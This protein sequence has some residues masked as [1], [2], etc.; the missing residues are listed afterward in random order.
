MLVSIL[1]VV[2]TAFAQGGPIQTVAAAR[3][4]QPARGP[5]AVDSA[6]ALRSAHRAQES[7]EFTRKLYLPREAGVGS[8]HCDVRIG[9]W[10]VW[11]DETNDR[12]PPPENAHIIQ[13]RAKLLALLDS[14]AARFP[15]D[16]WVAAQEVRYL[17]EAKRFGDATRVAD[18]CVAGGSTYRCRAY[19]AVALHDSGAVAAADSASTDALA[20]MPDSVRCKWMDIKLLLDDDIADRYAHANCITRERLATTFWRLT[21][22]LY[23][24][25][26]DFRSEFLARVAHGEM[27]RD[28]R[29][30]MG[31]TTES[32]FRET[33]L[34]YGYDTWFVRDDPPAGS[35]AEAPVAG[36]REGGSGYNFVPA[37]EVF[38]SPVDLREDDWDL[39]QRTARTLYGPSYARRFTSIPAPQIAIF[40][41]GDSALVV[42][43]YD[44]H[45][46]TLFARRGLE[47]AL[48][49]VPIDSDKL[50]DPRGT[51]DS[52]AK[53]TG[54]LTTSAPWLP[55]IASVELLDSAYKSAARARVGV[56]LP[57]SEGRLGI[58][59]LLLF[60]PRSADSLPHRL[61]DALP[62]ALHSDEVNG[63][64][65]VGVFW[66]AYGVRPAGESFAVAIGIDRIQDGWMR[67][68]AQRLHLAS[69]FSPM[70]LRWTELPEGANGIA[71]RSVT[72]DL[73]K[74]EPGRYEISVS[75]SSMAGLPIVAKR[76]VTIRR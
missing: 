19:G 53:R 7:F 26:G 39:K 69:P 37:Y 70:K 13:A 20:A 45:D 62:L 76:E 30:P 35:M 34:R 14:T 68:A 55:M 59:D 43:A 58:S 42:A 32:A 50:D 51:I 44:V 25:N 64:T 72:L 61:E 74:L 36:Y 67:R 6:R 23:L 65:P 22:P 57:A 33:A 52:S 16:E 11:N 73:T 24:R 3:R 63:N 28:S 46:D 21:T 48:F 40:R 15:G 56:R 12:K 71:S 41:R 2:A 60:A 49:T 54:L 75:V 17:I 4:D 10:C 47:A 8:H 1:V 5:A 27:E 9:R 38:A 66:E 18:R 31:S 29:T